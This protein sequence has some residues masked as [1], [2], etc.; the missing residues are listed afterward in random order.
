M[1]R[2]RLSFAA[3]LAVAAFLAGQAAR[4]HILAPGQTV[5]TDLFDLMSSATLV[6][7]TSGSFNSG[8]STG[9]YIE[10]VFV[11]P[12]NV[13]GKND[14]TW[15]I[16]VTN[17][18]VPVVRIAASSFAGFMTDV[19]TNIGIVPPGF[20]SSGGDPDT[21]DRDLTG[22]IIGFNYPFGL[23]SGQATSMLDIETNATTFGPGFL[24]ITEQGTLN[25]PVTVTVP[26]F[27]PMQ[28][29]EP[30]TWVMMLLGFLGLGFAFRQSR[31]KLSMA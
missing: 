23:S 3:A 19:G 2:I 26:A 21:V 28:V 8:N 4:G 10:D 17:G 31:R 5:A 16:G 29:P 15:L 1:D 11:D 18:P 24:S 12:A 7:T 30:A 14:L 6:A 22:V 25:P 9:Q 27:G 20:T 13:L